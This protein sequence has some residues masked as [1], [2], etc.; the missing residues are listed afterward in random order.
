MTWILGFCILLLSEIIKT[1]V[2][3]NRGGSNIYFKT[4]VESRNLQE[5]ENQFIQ[6]QTLPIGLAEGSL[7][8]SS[9]PVNEDL[10]LDIDLSADPC[11]NFFQYACG[12]FINST[13]GVNGYTVPLDPFHR[14]S[15][16]SD[17]VQEHLRRPS[18]HNEAISLRKAKQLFL[19]CMDE[20]AVEARGITPIL[21]FLNARG[22]WPVLGQWDQQ[23]FDMVD[24]L[25]RT[26]P[27]KKDWEF[28]YQ[29]TGTIIGMVIQRDFKSKGQYAMY[30]D[31]PSLSQLSFKHLINHEVYRL[32]INNFYNKAYEEYLVDTAVLLGADLKTARR[33]M[34]DVFEFETKLAS[35][36]LFEEERRLVEQRYNKMTIFELT[37]RFPKFEWLRYLRTVLMFGNININMRTEVV[38]WASPYYDKLWPILEQTS[39]RTLA[40]Y[41][42]FRAMQPLLTSISKHYRYVALRY[43]ATTNGAT[44]PQLQDR[45]H[46]CSDKVIQVMS[47]VTSKIYIERNFNQTTM[48]YVTMIKDIVRSVLTNQIRR[49]NW[50]T[51]TTRFN[52]LRKMRSIGIDIGFPKEILD[53]SYLDNFYRNFDFGNTFFENWQEAITENYRIVIRKLVERPS[54]EWILQPESVDAIYNVGTNT[55]ELPYA[56]MGAPHF[57]L[58]YPASMNFGGIGF[59]IG[60]EHEHG[61]DIT[62]SSFDWNGLIRRYW[63]RPS[64]SN[65][66]RKQNCFVRQYSDYYLSDIGLAVTNGNKTVIEDIC[67]NVGLKIAYQA[68]KRFKRV[69]RKLNDRIVS[70]LPF[71][72]DQLFFLNYARSWCFDASP[73]FLRR[74][75]YIDHYA[76]PRLRAIGPLQ[77]SKEFAET[78]NCPVGSF[79]NPVRKCTMW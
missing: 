53:D 44:R 77:N 38:L 59:L 61:F 71:N 50:L 65:F 30:I 17:L 18:A 68:Y 72:Q 39:D 3:N 8:E 47:W 15:D 20:R 10:L 34:R 42:L 1:Q 23:R 25:A 24:L 5:F 11:E 6:F 52:L 4:L 13:V 12:R 62:G 79:M 67:D 49:A 21:D 28:H 70:G 75:M 2:N 45:A 22:G 37:L 46:F 40:N 33:D 60:Q 19:S 7:N 48:S 63:S 51:R 55:I 66:L 74:Y 31:Q 64:F 35:I 73:T 56:M 27:L 29:P 32:G 14:S 58:R 69:N 57:S 76:F 16:L 43:S 9:L 78:F 41:I 54:N 26:R 36:M